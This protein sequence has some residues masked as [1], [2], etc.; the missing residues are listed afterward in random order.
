MSD[1]PELQAGFQAHVISGAA[2]PTE[3][4]VGTEAASAD[5]RLRV[6]VDAYRQRLLE[7]VGV[8]Y[9]GVAA[10]MSPEAFRALGLRYIERYPSQHPSVRWF[11]RHLAECLATDPE[12]ADR[13]YLAELAGFEWARGLAFDAADAPTVSLDELGAVPADDWPG[14]RLSL[15]PALQRGHCNWNIGPIWRAV[16]A[17]EPPPP[18][19]QLAGATQWAIWRRDLTI[20]WRILDDAEAGAIDAFGNGATFAEVCVVLCDWLP[21]SGVPGRAAGMLRQWLTEGLI[22][23]MT[24]GDPV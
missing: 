12:Y 8:D 9:P 24:T 20:Y 18:P 11:G 23:A 19:E 10:L 3:Q 21:D 7:A 17:G 22:D 14:L 1:L 4:F 13:P 2:P 15:T 16:D 5:A 6:Y